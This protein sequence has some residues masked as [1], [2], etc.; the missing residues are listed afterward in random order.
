MESIEIKLNI[1]KIISE[2]QNEQLLQTIY[3]Y[4]KTATAYKDP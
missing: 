2:I 4:L 1:H 3:D